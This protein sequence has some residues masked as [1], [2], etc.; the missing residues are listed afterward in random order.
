MWKLK[1]IINQTVKEVRR[2]SRKMLRQNENTTYENLQNIVK[3]SLR[4]QFIA[5]N[6]IYKKKI[7]NNPT[8]NIKELGK[9]EQIQPNISRRKE[10]TIRAG[11]ND[12]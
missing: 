10:T 1:I 7:S 3:A 5:I 8:L 6:T 11:K 9:E 2:E 4:G 12:M